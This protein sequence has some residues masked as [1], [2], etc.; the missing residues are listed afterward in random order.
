MLAAFPLTTAT[1]PGTSGGGASSSLGSP[2]KS[3]SFFARQLKKVA[4][5]LAY[6]P[7]VLIATGRK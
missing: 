5:D 6:T 4:V 2:D 7:V 3:T 1:E